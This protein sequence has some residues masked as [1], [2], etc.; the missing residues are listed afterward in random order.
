MKAIILHRAEPVIPENINQKTKEIDINSDYLGKVLD[1]ESKPGVEV[2]LISNNI[3]HASKTVSRKEI[4]KDLY[5]RFPGTYIL[6]NEKQSFIVHETLEQI[7]TIV[8][9]R[10]SPNL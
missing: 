10:Y 6:C 7:Q 3:N 2:L 1:V 8:N 5:V 4:E 9:S